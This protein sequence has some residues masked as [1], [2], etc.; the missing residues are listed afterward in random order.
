MKI[1][2]SFCENRVAEFFGPL[3]S[4]CINCNNKWKETSKKIS[5]EEL[6]MC[7]V[8]CGDSVTI[9]LTAPKR[10]TKSIKIFGKK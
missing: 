10:N 1:K 8:E 9:V 2:C 5:M 6:M 3:G 7:G 4:V